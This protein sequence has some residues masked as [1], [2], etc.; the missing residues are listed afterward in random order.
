M[1]NTDQGQWWYFTFGKGHEHEGH[2]VKI[3]GGYI[4]A[5]TEM[6]SRYGMKW[7]FQY[8]QEFWEHLE[9]S[10][11]QLSYELETELIEN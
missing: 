5:R 1:A 7:A 6:I 8:S 10:R 9:A 4:E 11:G 3:F 2:Y